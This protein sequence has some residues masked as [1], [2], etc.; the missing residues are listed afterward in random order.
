MELKYKRF[1][2]KMELQ[3]R[4]EDFNLHKE[5][6]EHEKFNRVHSRDLSNDKNYLLLYFINRHNKT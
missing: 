5:R 3:L 1:S 4:D 6:W 2:R